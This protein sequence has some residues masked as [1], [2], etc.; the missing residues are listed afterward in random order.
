MVELAFNSKNIPLQL[1]K[2]LEVKLPL[3]NP[4]NNRMPK[5]VTRLASVGLVFVL[6]FL[7]SFSLW[8]AFINHEAV[9]EVAHST[10]LNNLFERAHYAVGQEESLERNYRLE[11]RPTIFLSH[12]AA[13]AD[14]EAALA[15]VRANGEPKDQ[16]LVDEI[17]VLHQ[18]Y[19]SAMNRLFEAVDAKDM[20]LAEKIDGEE[21]DLLCIKIAELVNQA[22]QNHQNEALS[23][24]AELNRTQQLI[25]IS[26]PIVF[27][28]GMVLIIFFLFLL[29]TYRRQ[30]VQDKLVNEALQVANQSISRALAK[31]KELNELKSR[32]VS[33]TSHEFRTPLTAISVIADILKHKS[34]GEKEA[35][36]LEL[37]RGIQ[38]SVTNMTRLL[39]DVLLIS[40]SETGKL[41]SQPAL[42][43]LTQF[44]TGLVEE[45]QLSTGNK[46]TITFISSPPHIT[47]WMDERLLQ[48]TLANLLS[49]AIKYSPEGSPVY[50]E[51]IGQADQVVFKIKDQGIGI[52][53]ADQSQL[54]ESFH[55]AGNVG[56]IPGTGLGLAIAKNT[57][58]LLGGQITFSSHLGVGTTFVICLPLKVKRKLPV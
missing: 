8:V 18:S 34:P 37:L 39:D 51:V 14:L 28:I 11:A 42:L 1:E 53:E 30:M 19:L 54:F 44:C 58:D 21:A 10:Y 25:F 41:D 40:K 57:V 36:K 43:D 12:Q 24:L 35:D 52:P 7:T 9:I 29:R 2:E 46:R 22:A 47:G 27:V 20:P 55:R 16:A 17:M 4:T 48:Q 15:E 49:N 5:I 31:E 3:K 26:T 38:S 56:N 23:Y 50:F 33:M 13:A 32:F 6:F 45:L